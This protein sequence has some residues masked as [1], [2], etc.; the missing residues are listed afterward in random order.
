[1][2]ETSFSKAELGQARFL[3]M[4]P[5]AHHGYPQPEDDFEFMSVT[6]DPDLYC[7]S[8]CVGLRQRAPFLMRNEPRWGKKSILQLNW[9]FD[10][11]FTKPDAWEKVFKPAGISCRPVLHA[12]SKKI[13]ETVVQLQ[14]TKS[15]ELYL[16]AVPFELC[17]TC[18]SK[19]FAR[20]TRG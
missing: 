9:V 1:M 19:K 15:A 18:G 12:R 8:C 10:E 5:L 6:Y 20:V 4:Y 2:V 11:Y 3:A 16:S 14:I 7:K 13:L 17:K